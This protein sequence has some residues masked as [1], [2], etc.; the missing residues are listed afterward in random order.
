[1]AE[2]RRQL[3]PADEAWQ[4]KWML[5]FEDRTTTVPWRGEHR[6]FRSPNVVPLERYRTDEDWARVCNVFWPRRW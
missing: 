6:W 2:I 5:P 3:S 4:R 1:M